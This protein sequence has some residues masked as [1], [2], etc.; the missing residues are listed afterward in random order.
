MARK[1]IRAIPPAILARISNFDQDD[2]VVACAKVL[3]PEDVARY[4]HLGIA[5]VSGKL[6]TPTLAVP[7]PASGRYSRANV[8]GY[9]KIRKDLPKI[10]KTFELE[11]PNWGRLDTHPVYWTRDVYPREFY[12]PK[13]VELSITL[14]EERNGL[15]VLKFA[16]EQVLSRRMANFE[17]ELLYNLNLLQENVGAVDVFPSASTL[18]EYSSTVRVDWQILPP[19]TVDHVLRQMLS[20]KRPVTLEQ[21]NTMR[22]R[23]TVISRLRPKSYVVGS[24]G[25]VRYFGAKFGEDFVVFENIRY[26]NALYVMYESWPDLSKRSRVDLLNGPRDSFE[27]I[28][29]GGRWEETLTAHV[30]VYRRKKQA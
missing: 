15:Y 11:A 25:F 8:E 4:A 6:V 16:I 17:K 18:A 24:D 22:E 26:G 3:K 30:E 20:G 9:E 14:I 13:E 21:E 10:P 5:V 12:P 19:G 2:V 7:N 29:H 1:N 28:T 27:R 23:I